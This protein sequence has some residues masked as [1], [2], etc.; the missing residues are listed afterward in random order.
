MPRRPTRS[1]SDPRTVRA[2]TCGTPWPSQRLD[3]L[4]CAVSLLCLNLTWYGV[5]RRRTN[6]QKRASMRLA[7]YEIRTKTD[8]MIIKIDPALSVLMVVRVALAP[9]VRISVAAQQAGLSAGSAPTGF[10]RGL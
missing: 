3:C 2:V 9:P 1:D 10:W 8:G 5:L 7:S 4:V 6:V